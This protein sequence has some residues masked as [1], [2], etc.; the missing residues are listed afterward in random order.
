LELYD[1]DAPV[2]WLNQH[3][4]LSKRDLYEHCLALSETGGGT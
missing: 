4:F 2:L 3:D 1:L